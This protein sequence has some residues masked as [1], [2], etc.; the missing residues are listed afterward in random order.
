ML[1]LINVG[2]S[3]DYNVEAFVDL[4]E[5][6]LYR[7]TDFTSVMYPVQKQ[8]YLAQVRGQVIVQEQ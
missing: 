1:I 4:L 8:L 2:V 7:P 5:R 3:Q 6:I